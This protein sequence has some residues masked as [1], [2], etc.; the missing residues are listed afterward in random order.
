MRY[1]EHNT[2]RF[3]KP[4]HW[5]AGAF[6]LL[7]LRE[8]RLL[9][10]GAP[11]VTLLPGA[12]P[13]D[14]TPAIALDPCGEVHWVRE[15]TLE[16]IRSLSN[17]PL[18]L[19]RLRVRGAEWRAES[20]LVTVQSVWLL[21]RSAQGNA[22]RVLRFDA[23]D[24]YP[25][26]ELEGNGVALALST[27]GVKGA[28]ALWLRGDGSL[29]LTRF[30]ASGRRGSAYL[31]PFRSSVA[32]LAT[33]PDGRVVLLDPM[34]PLDPCNPV[35]WRLWLFDPCADEGSQWRLLFSQPRRDDGCH[36]EASPFTPHLL[37]I[38]E[39]GRIYL[40]SHDTGECWV[41]S[42]DGE[43]SARIPDAIP[44]ALR[45]TRGIVGGNVVVV[46]G[47]L[48]VAELI[49]SSRAPLSSSES[50]PTFI[51]PTL[52]SPEGVPSGWMRADLDVEVGGDGA[53]EVDV[54][55]TSDPD[56]I[57]EVERILARNDL[58]SSER[59]RRLDGRLAWREQDK[60]LYRGDQPTPLRFPLHQVDG[61]H[62]WLRVRLHHAPGGTTQELRSLRVLWPNISF[63]RHLP[64][65]YGED[66]AGAE[67]LR[68]FLVP[69]ESVFGDL[70]YDLSELP[71]RIDPR[72]SPDEW[73]PFLLR[74]LGLPSPVELTPVDQRRLLLRATDLLMLRGTQ[75]GLERLLEI[76][77]GRDFA[78]FDVAAGA[79]PWT[80]P[81]ES[82]PGFQ[83]PRLG[84]DTLVLCQPRPGFR[85]GDACLRQT[86]LGYHAA[87]PTELF[88]RRSR[89]VEVRIGAD[90]DD[91]Q[92]LEPLL[93]RFL[94]YFIPAHCRYELTFVAPS[95]SRIKPILD[96]RLR[97][98]PPND[99]RLGDT[100]EPG[101]WRLPSP[102]RR[103]V[104]LGPSTR[105]T[106]EL[107]LT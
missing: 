94:P 46:S 75:A 107:Y 81:E 29:E 70:E 36:A 50:L 35:A 48:G 72:T 76:L 30:D 77:V 78:V 53:V 32:R 14:D 15:Q 11:T 74:W 80:L 95:E 26:E 20:L 25:L 105:L 52:I 71:R 12:S 66:S 84:C 47:R 43:V 102:S 89:F 4:E 96:E 10:V 39:S 34:P 19:G 99:S 60:K 41:L 104:F 62:L 67:L 51:T 64:A 65:V 61:T 28:W 103:G 63:E 13:Q 8:K 18:V 82:R 92:R 59:L 97:L 57:R 106:N 3:E 54:A 73:L 31:A 91:R 58:A 33:T 9:T 79:A 68:R 69:L 87:D 83:A 42:L 85:A 1:V 24:L 38:D 88:A 56:A 45:P 86:S 37:A 2:Y 101:G 17:G 23:G 7:E 93:L 90:A 16:L 44:G 40:V 55:A 27:D 6:E 22:S 98:G 21:V 5:H 49:P 100:S